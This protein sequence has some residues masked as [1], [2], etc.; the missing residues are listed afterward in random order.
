MK[1]K[2]MQNLGVWGAPPRRAASLNAAAM[3]HCL[4]DWDTN[5]N[6]TSG[7][8]SNNTPTT[9]PNSSASISKKVTSKTKGKSSEK[10]SESD[11][12]AI[13]SPDKKIVVKKSV[14]ENKYK[15]QKSTTQRACKKSSFSPPSPSSDSSQDDEDDVQEEKVIKKKTPPT[16]KIVS[17]PSS[18]SSQDEEDDVPEKEDEFKMDMKDMIVKKRIA[19]LNASAIMTASYGNYDAIKPSKSEKDDSPKKTSDKNSSNKFPLDLSKKSAQF[20]QKTS[21]DSS[22]SPEKKKKKKQLDLSEEDD[23]DELPLSSNKKEAPKK[24]SF[25]DKKTKSGKLLSLTSSSPSKKIA[26]TIIV[27]IEDEDIKNQLIASA[28]KKAGKHNQLIEYGGGNKLNKK[29]SSP[30]SNE[31]RS[32]ALPPK[33]RALPDSCSIYEDED[34]EIETITTEG[35]A[36]SAAE[37]AANQPPLALNT[38]MN[39]VDLMIDGRVLHQGMYQVVHR[40]ET[41][42]TTTAVMNRDQQNNAESQDGSRKFAPLGAISSLQAASSNSS[43]ERISSGPF[44][45]SA[46][47]AH[48]L[49]GFYQPAGPLI[50]AASPHSQ[51][52]VSTAPPTATVQPTVLSTNNSINNTSSG[53]GKR[54]H[55]PE[56]ERSPRSSPLKPTPTAIPH[57]HYPYGHFTP[58]PP[59]PP[60]YFDPNQPQQHHTLLHPQLSTY[61]N[62]YHPYAAA[63]AHPPPPPHPSSYRHHT[64]Y[65]I[66]AGYYPF[67]HGG[68]YL[69]PNPTLAF[70][71]APP[72]QVVPPNS[73]GGGVPAT[74]LEHSRPSVIT[75]S[76]SVRPPPL[77]A[78]ATHQ[79]TLQGT[80]SSFNYA[81]L[82]QHPYSGGRIIAPIYALAPHNLMDPNHHYPQQQPNPLYPYAFPNL[83]SQ[84]N[85]PSTQG[86]SSTISEASKNESAGSQRVGKGPDSQ[87]ILPALVNK[88]REIK[89]STSSG[90]HD[91]VKSRISNN[92][93]NTKTSNLNNTSTTIESPKNVTSGNFF[94][95][96]LNSRINVGGAGV[97]SSSSSISSI[98]S[99]CNPCIPTSSTIKY[100]LLI[101]RSENRPRKKQDEEVEEQ[102]AERDRELA[103]SSSNNSNN[104]DDK[105]GHPGLPNGLLRMAT[106]SVQQNNNH[107]SSSSNN[108]NNNSSSSSLSSASITRVTP[109]DLKSKIALCRIGLMNNTPPDLSDQ[110][111]GSYGTDKDLLIHNKNN[112]VYLKPPRRLTQNEEGTSTTLPLKKLKKKKDYANS[113]KISMSMAQCAVTAV[114]KSQGAPPK[115]FQS[116]PKTL[117]KSPNIFNKGRPSSSNT[118]CSNSPSSSRSSSR[119][120]SLSPRERIPGS[121]SKFSPKMSKGLNMNGNGGVA[122]GSGGV[123]GGLCFLNSPQTK[124]KVMQLPSSFI[125][126]GSIPKKHKGPPKLSNGWSWV[127]E[128]F[129]Q[130]VHLNNEDPPTLRICYS[131]MKHTEGD[132][133][134]VRDLTALWE[135]PDNGEMMLSLLWY[136]RPEH[137]DNGRNNFELSD[138][139]YA[140]KH[141]DFTSVAC[142]EDKCYVMTYNEY[143]RYRKFLRMIEEH[144]TPPVSAIPE[145]ESGYYRQNFLPKCRVAPDRVFLCRRVYESRQ[146]RLLKK[147]SLMNYL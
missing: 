80:S 92:S 49:A 8:S 13:S 98:S 40:F 10:S 72:P 97:V 31:P 141:R 76:A 50:R 38:E 12:S 134:K 34:E 125:S 77:P 126:C 82:G 63:A 146:R 112:R 39:K 24:Q 21:V 140:S 53:P 108:N 119:N 46:S 93:V 29:N 69:A 66:T 54:A 120:S 110:K 75:T 62:P 131:S 147:S 132:F 138:E 51:T 56:K 99:I 79:L 137:L 144:V 3:V 114:L 9:S 6:T 106:T 121:F 94:N 78:T 43:G 18:D 33:K 5:R 86:S 26:N 123:V 145:L 88:K 127:G 41:I 30:L 136:Y 23:E 4:Y 96:N 25:E 129:E 36:R 65:P 59:P 20:S 122:T 67:Q 83:P 118:N 113:N 48:S 74:V 73:I 104:T 22:Q 55:S 11:K 37:E 128:G 58:Y 81:T 124:K 19:S 130:K 111:R 116:H 15:K 101:K 117:P 7:G 139:I 47:T 70:P 45:G 133:V 64:P 107:R 2:Q 115:L 87:N 27:E 42:S 32:S 60:Q 102:K 103:K 95:K 61:A 16:K 52:T 135:H 89:S 109:K 68:Y 57:P 35:A 1:L 17:P 100:P 105:R 44:I 90:N 14:K 28:M 84:V 142:V 85:A 71:P 143:C 91:E